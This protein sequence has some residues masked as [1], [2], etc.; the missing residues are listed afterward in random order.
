[1]AQDRRPGRAWNTGIPRQKPG[2]EQETDEEDLM[3]DSAGQTEFRVT[4]SKSYVKI[5]Y[6]VRVENGPVIKG[7]DR[8]EEM[9]FVTGYGQVIPGL[10]RRLIGHTR[11]EKLSFGVPAEEAFGPRLPEL[12]IEKTRDEF[13]FPQGT[14]PYVGMQLPLIGSGADSPDTVMIREIKGDNIV[15]DCNHPLSGLPLLYDLEI[16]EARPAE[17]KDTC[18]EWDEKP[19]NETCGGC[20]PHEI[21]LGRPSHGDPQTN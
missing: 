5:R 3:A 12:V 13:H 1:L 21:V 19:V 14:E 16:I 9:D 10:E 15:I 8:L 2:N 4:D 6:T 17:E 11:G 20:A 18:A 7:A